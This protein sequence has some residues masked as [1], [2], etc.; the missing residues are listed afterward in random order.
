MARQRVDARAEYQKILADRQYFNS[1]YLWIN[2]K[3]LD[4][5][6][7]LQ[8]LIY[9]DTQLL[10]DKAIAT[11]EEAGKPVRVVILK[12]RQEGVSTYVEGYIFKKTITN[13]LTRSLVV[14]HDLP[15]A[16]GLFAMSQLYYDCLPAELKPM[17][18]YSTRR[19]L[20]FENP[21]DR[22]RAHNPGLR[23]KIYIGT[24]ANINLGRSETIRHCHL[25]ELAFWDDPA[26][27]LLSVSQSIPDAPGTSV[28]IESTANG[29]GDP[30]YDLYYGAKSGDNDYIPLFFPWF[31]SKEYQMDGD[32]IEKWSDY[33]EWLVNKFNLTDAQLRWRR[34]AIRNKCK[35]SEKKFN[36]EYPATEE[37]A[38]LFTG[39]PVFDV[40]LITA[41]LR[42]APEPKMTGD[43]VSKP[44]QPGILFF[45]KSE[46]GKLRI[47]EEPIKETDYV[48]GADVAE[49][50][51]GGNY[52]AGVVLKRDPL[53]QVAE[54]HGRVTPD[55]FA[56]ILGDVGYFYNTALEKLLSIII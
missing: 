3:G 38:F 13:P 8:Q 56:D 14:S 52:S 54:W 46:Q 29:Y 2:T 26:A 32:P 6:P 37:E 11:Q 20:L 24:A 49:G 28:F 39:T 10:L 42:G 45:R 55:V 27:T 23:S 12:A 5:V 1:N 31:L 25:S 18:R 30:F 22:R 40:A 36:Q 41:M 44:E 43:I 35:N 48:I 16:M 50:V 51:Q 47:W 9:N 7:R 21:D 19:E 33:E 53:M 15:S 17:K 34:W 4:G